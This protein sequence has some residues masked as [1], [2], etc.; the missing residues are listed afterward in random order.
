MTTPGYQR[1][2]DVL[3]A[4]VRGNDPD[5]GERL[6][7]DTVLNRGDVVRA[8][9][10]AIVALESQNARARRRA[11][12]PESVGKSWSE[13]EERRLKDEYTRQHMPIRDIAKRHGRTTRAIAGRLELL[14]LLKPEDRTTRHSFMAKSQRKEGDE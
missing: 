3:R 12:L 1:S 8:L 14:G 2:R 4:L 5:T 13:E 7:R 10:E 11:Q 9:V 6:D